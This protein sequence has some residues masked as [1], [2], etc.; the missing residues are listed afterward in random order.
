MSLNIEPFTRMPLCL[1]IKEFT[2]SLLEEYTGSGRLLH[3]S[4][5]QHIFYFNPQGE[6]ILSNKLMSYEI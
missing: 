3:P 5:Q 6:Y 4:M 2:L 1:N